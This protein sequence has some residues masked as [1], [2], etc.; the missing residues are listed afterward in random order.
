M[1]VFLAVRQGWNFP[2]EVPYT[3]TKHH[4]HIRRSLICLT[5]KNLDNSISPSESCCSVIT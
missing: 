4:R 1:A 3:D 5:W 2:Y